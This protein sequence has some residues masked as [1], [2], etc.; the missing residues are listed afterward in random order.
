MK[1]WVIRTSL[2]T[3]HLEYRIN[4]REKQGRLDWAR[5]LDMNAK[6]IDAYQFTKQAAQAICDRAEDKWHYIYEAVPVRI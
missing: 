5:R 2:I 6:G 1:Y 4:K 3:G